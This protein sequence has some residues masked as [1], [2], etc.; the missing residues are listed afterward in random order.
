M[1]NPTPAA[2]SVM[3]LAKNNALLLFIGELELLN[4]PGASE[5]LAPEYT[6]WQLEVNR[7]PPRIWGKFR[8]KVA[9][10]TS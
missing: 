8:A 9:N 1:A 6:S 2:M 10:R 3:K 7:L 5:R 4:L